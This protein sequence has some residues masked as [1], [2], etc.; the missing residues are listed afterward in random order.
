MNTE[1]Y[2]NHL[3]IVIITT[4]ISDVKFIYVTYSCEFAR[5]VI[6]YQSGQFLQHNYFILSCLN[7]DKYSYIGNQTQQHFQLKRL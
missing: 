6:I 7:L 3:M 2:L 5:T 4:T 1:S